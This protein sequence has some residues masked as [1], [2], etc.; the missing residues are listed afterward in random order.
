MSVQETTKFQPTWGGGVLVGMMIMG[1]LSVMLPISKRWIAIV[2]A[3]GTSAGMM[4]L[5]AAAL[6]GHRELVN[7]A[8]MGMGLFT[9]FFSVGALSMMMDMT[10]EGATGLYMGL[11]GMA[12]AFGNGTASFGSGALHTGLIES[13]VLAPNMA[14]FGIFGVEAVGMLIAAVIL[15]SLSVERF[16]NISSRCSPRIRTGDGSEVI[17]AQARR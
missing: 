4:V 1:L 16:H 15:L 8:L 12:Q 2:G 6:T 9:G 3:L 11:W 17:S 7:P 10:I 14:Y 13:G 5:A